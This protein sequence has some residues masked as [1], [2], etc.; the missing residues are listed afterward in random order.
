MRTGF[1]VAIANPT[2]NYLETAQYLVFKIKSDVI[3]WA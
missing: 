1:F 3:L 2:G